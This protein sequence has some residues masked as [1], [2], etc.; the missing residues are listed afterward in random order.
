VTSYFGA[1]PA[2]LVLDGNGKIIIKDTEIPLTSYA[3]TTFINF[4]NQKKPIPEISA[5]DVL[6][7]TVDP[8]V[9]KGKLVFIG[10][11]DPMSGADFL[12]HRCVSVSR[13]KDL[14]NDGS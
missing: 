2:D 12:S 4:R 6:N 9:F 14:G 7:G 11:T 8:S 13:G 10:V 3:A 5:V 1:S